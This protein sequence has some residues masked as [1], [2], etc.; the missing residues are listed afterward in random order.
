M[1][2]FAYFNFFFKNLIWEM[3]METYCQ[4]LRKIGKQ[5]N[6]PA[7]NIK[8]LNG[9]IAKYLGAFIDDNEIE[10]T[11]DTLAFLFD[12]I[13]NELAENIIENFGTELREII[14]FIA[15]KYGITRTHYYKL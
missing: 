5:E 1:W 15:E 12:K 4:L 9:S 14:P 6:D 8:I 3:F 7:I 13:T 10:P 2:M 11:E